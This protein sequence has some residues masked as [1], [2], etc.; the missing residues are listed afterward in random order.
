MKAPET[1]L[2]WTGKPLLA[3][4]F[5]P[6]S[7]YSRFLRSTCENYPV[8]VWKAAEGFWAVLNLCS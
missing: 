5:N 7:S 2:R 8:P 4:N 6:V 1:D 3:K